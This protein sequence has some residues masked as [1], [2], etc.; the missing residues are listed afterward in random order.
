MKSGTKNLRIASVLEIIMG[1]ASL[2]LTHY[3][4][5]HGDATV[6]GISAPTALGLLVAA[7]GLAIFQILAGIFGLMMADKKSLLTVF[8]GVALFIPQ[9]AHFFNMKGSIGMIL[10]NIV[11]LVIP[12][13]YLNSAYKNFKAN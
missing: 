4:V 3:L 11:V 12:Y 6:A 8:F 13:L 9:L 1:A 5:G 10:A 7:Y 2:F